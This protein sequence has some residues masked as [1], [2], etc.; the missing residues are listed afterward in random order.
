MRRTNLA[1]ARG[2]TLVCAG[3]LFIH[4]TARAYEPATTHAGLTAR[5]VETSR[6][7]HLLA[8]LGRPLGL[9]EPL[10]IGFDLFGRDERRALQARL[11][12]L[13]PAGGYRPGPDGVAGAAHWVVAGAVLAKTPPERGADH[14]LDPATGKGLYDDPGLSGVAHGVR[15]LFDGGTS[16]RGLAAGTAFT[17]S[18][19]SA[20]DWIES[21]DNDLG[22]PVFFDNWERAVSLAE[23]RERESALVRA[24]L[25]MGGVMAVLEDAG[26]PAFVRNDFRGAFLQ[27]DDGSAYEQFVAEH[28]GRAGLPAAAAPVSRPDITSFFASAD[29]KGLANRT[30]RRF[31]SEGTIP[32]D[33]SLERNS[34][35][36]DVLRRARES[37]VFPSPTLSGLVL[38]PTQHRRYLALEGHRVLAYENNGTQVRFFLDDAVYADMARTLLPE[39]AGYAA[40]LLNHLVRAS[41]EM[42]VMGNKVTVRLDGEV[43]QG[44]ALRVFAED[45]SGRRRELPGVAA[46]L[47]P[48]GEVAVA[49]PVGAK[50]LAAVLRGRDAGEPFVA[51]GEVTL[52]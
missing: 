29:G 21:P 20:L 39:V 38:R 17:L 5:A 28:Y 11:D 7:H 41:L 8:R 25:A 6:L 47:E 37:L 44:G 35:A 42:S 50:K 22:L 36:A 46:T 15:L 45:G 49:V 19:K 31:F 18:G 52:P 16:V 51:A 2:A 34:K 30:Q 48:G 9:L 13:D 12:A 3:A 14:F 33:V 32:A 1:R 4:A 43:K 27:R 23:P 24:L 26:Q 40:G 10:R